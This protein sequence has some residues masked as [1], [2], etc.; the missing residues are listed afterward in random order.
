MPIADCFEE[1]I[2]ITNLT[3]ENTNARLWYHSLQ[4]REYMGKDLGL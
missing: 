1:K 4:Q 3:K 2:E